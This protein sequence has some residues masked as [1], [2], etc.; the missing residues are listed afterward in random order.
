MFLIILLYLSVNNSI[1]FQY[2]LQ[3]IIRTA[4]LVKSKTFPRETSQTL[5]A[6]NAIFDDVTHH[7]PSTHLRINDNG[8]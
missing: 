3:M 7:L 8:L 4:S 6:S 5:G 2:K 1:L